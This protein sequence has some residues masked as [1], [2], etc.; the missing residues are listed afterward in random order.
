MAA[1][2]AW[3]SWATG[4]VTVATVISTRMSLQSPVRRRVGANPLG[5]VRKCIGACVNGLE[6]HL[7][8]TLRLTDLSQ[9]LRD[10]QERHPAGGKH[11]R[12]CTDTGAV[13]LPWRIFLQYREKAARD[14]ARNPPT[15]ATQYT[16]T[17][18]ANRTAPTDVAVLAQSETY[19]ITG[20]QGQTLSDYTARPSNGIYS[21]CGCYGNCA[22]ETKGFDVVP[23]TN[24]FVAAQADVTWPRSVI[25]FPDHI[26]TLRRE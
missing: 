20:G 13:R 7:L 22:G 6:S 2:A 8:F 18:T 24:T 23:P 11:G 12:D 10:G 9:V 19:A 5:T 16:T 15:T 17:T 4:V 1:I 25:Q 14:T 3:S 21:F 26:L